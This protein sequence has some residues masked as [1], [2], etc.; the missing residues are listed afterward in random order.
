MLLFQGIF[1]SGLVCPSLVLRQVFQRAFSPYQSRGPNV[2][3][4]SQVSF[5]PLQHPV[6]LGRHLPTH[7]SLRPL[8]NCGQCPSLRSSTAPPPNPGSISLPEELRSVY[9]WDHRASLIYP[10]S[11][12]AQGIFAF[13]LHI[14][15][16]LSSLVQIPPF[17][18]RDLSK[19]ERKS[20]YQEVKSFQAPMEACNTYYTKS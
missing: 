13:T 11:P 5:S 4:P 9:P 10:E 15:G 7:P 1:Q 6:T 19:K 8:M 3:I 18:V 16:L 17:L 2:G 14:L 12:P 20:S